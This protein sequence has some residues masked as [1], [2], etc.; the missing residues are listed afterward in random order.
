MGTGQDLQ[1]EGFDRDAGP[2]DTP[3][4]HLKRK[5]VKG[6]RVSIASS[7]SHSS[8]SEHVI[9]AWM[10]LLAGV[11]RPCFAPTDPFS[12]GQQV[13]FPS[14]SEVWSEKL[15]PYLLKKVLFTDNRQ[16]LKFFLK[17]TE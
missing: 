1:N 13:P 14:Q 3:N 4:V 8:S 2:L 6:Y 11:F 7:A 17:A 12:A 16:S 10:F 9:S 5:T 15:L